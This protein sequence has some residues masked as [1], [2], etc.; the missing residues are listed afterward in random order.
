L[1]SQYDN[2]SYS[3]EGK[4]HEREPLLI[5]PE[6]A[7]LRDISSGDTVRIFNDRGACLAGAVVSG[8]LRAGVVALA[9]GAWFDPVDPG[10]SGTLERHGNP[11][12]LTADRGTSRLAQGST[13]GTTLVQVERAVDDESLAPRPF[14]P[15]ATLDHSETSVLLGRR[16]GDGRGETTR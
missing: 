8:D 14:E 12:V 5:N 7:A 6:D 4:I 15:P 13:A 10:V 9:T 16:S 3:R 2:G 11:N 1:H